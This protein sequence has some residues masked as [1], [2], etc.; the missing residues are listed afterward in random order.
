MVLHRLLIAD[1]TGVV[2]KAIE[3]QL[4]DSFMIETC[5]NGEGALDLIYRFEPDIILLDLQ[6]PIISGLD[7]LQMLRSVG[8]N[9]K[10]I[11]MTTL[12]DDYICRALE[13][14]QVS[15]LLLKPCMVGAVTACICDISFQ[16]RNCQNSDW[17]LEHE[18]DRILL[19]LGFRMGPARYAYVCHAVLCKYEDGF[20]FVTKC[21]YPKVAKH[22]G[23]TASQV[24]KGIRDAIK[25]AWK[26][27][28]RAVWQLYFPP[29]K[30][31]EIPCPSNE[32]FLAR[33]ANVLQHKT[34]QKRPYQPQREWA[35]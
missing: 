17:C 16:L 6:L 29:D 10:V 34:R 28:N 14:L 1:S 12:T 7:V 30:D 4:R 22:F 5:N 3:K 20:S 27:G 35:K 18:T 15:N 21:L 2:G 11:V 25:D 31:G 24:E 13:E 23:G 26:N 8:L 33:I 19:A 32:V 9:T